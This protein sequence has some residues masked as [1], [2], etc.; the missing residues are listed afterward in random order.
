M[1]R[2]HSLRF[3]ALEAR[4][5]L[6]K[7]HVVA[8]HPAAAVVSVPVVLTGTLAV[9]KNEAT[10]SQNIDGSSTTMV[11]V[12]GRLG[13]LGKVQGVW[14]ENA[15]QFGD[16]MGPDTIE[17]VSR[18]PKGTLSVS[19]NNQ[20]AGQLHLIGHSTGYYQ[21]A[22]R[23]QGGTGA[24]AKASEDGSIEVMVS[25]TKKAVESLELISTNT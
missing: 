19:F 8:V 25:S 11:P 5:L 3:D 20:N 9:D 1:R 14:Y 4:K 15:D 17:L 2:A 12:S 7:A 21:H 16:Y 24:F 13:T 10:T 18:N 22:Q 23:L 6:T